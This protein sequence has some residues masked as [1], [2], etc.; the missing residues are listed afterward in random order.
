MGLTE[1]VRQLPIQVKLLLISGPPILGM[2]VFAC[3]G[4]LARYDHVAN[5]EATAELAQLAPTTGQLVM[6]L[7]GEFDQTMSYYSTGGMR[8]E[9]KLKATQEKTNVALKAFDAQAKTVLTSGGIPAASAELLEKSVKDFAGM[10]S[11]REKTSELL[12]GHAQVASIYDGLAKAAL[13]PLLLLSELS[14]NGQLGNHATALNALLDAIRIGGFER[15]VL[16]D[17]LQAGSFAK[18]DYE[19][20]IGGI[21]SFRSHLEVFL[22]KAPLPAK[23]AFDEW[24]AKEGTVAIETFRGKINLEDSLEDMYPGSP[25]EWYAT[26]TSY[27]SGLAKVGDAVV[28][29]IAATLTSEKERATRHGRIF[30]IVA[31]FTV[32]LSILISRMAA[33]VLIRFLIHAEEVM[34]DVANGDVHQSVEVSGSDELSR[35]GLAI[36]FLIENLREIV[37]RVST[38]TD[39]IHSLADKLQLLSDALDMASKD[40]STHAEQMTEDSGS[41]SMAMGEVSESL[42]GMIHTMQEAAEQSREAAQNAEGAVQRVASTNETIRDLSQRSE[43]I[44][45]I[46]RIITSI[47]E[48]TNLLALNATIEAARAGEA[49]RGFAV[50][51]NEVKELAKDTTNATTEI[52]AKIAG[53]QQVSAAAVVAVDSIRDTVHTINEG[54]GSISQLM[55]AQTREAT[56][57]EA[58]LATV[59]HINDSLIDHVGSIKDVAGVTETN[60]NDIQDVSNMLSRLSSDFQAF[61]SKFRI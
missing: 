4:A 31:F 32:T 20:V 7:S 41:V 48:Q 29:S 34:R 21:H 61:A 55:L 38:H 14:H 11:L 44:S 28:V 39:T 42:A 26:H 16:Y 53:I 35:L 51:A 8:G 3:I 54:Q 45:Q 57:A 36:N 52:T 43:E 1:L 47:A 40:T 56:E 27:L 33:Q 13:T 10:A 46:V 58:H 37:T 2:A 59:G 17:S 30:L 6:E 24:K 50:V 19:H 12:V 15:T 9:D 22:A 49:G 18:G 23:V 5:V 60:S 25:D